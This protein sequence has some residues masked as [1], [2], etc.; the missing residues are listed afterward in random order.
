M[1]NRSSV[2]V[3]VIGTGLAGM[4]AALES[5][6]Q[7]SSVLALS[8][9]SDLHETNTNYAQGGIVTQG[10]KDTPELIAE[11][12][13]R[14][15]GGIN[16]RR[17]VDILARE[18]QGEVSRWLIERGGVPFDRRD[19]GAGYDYTREGAHSVRRIL[20][21]AD[22][23]GAAIQKKLMEQMD[24]HPRIT[25]RKGVTAVDLITNSHHSQDPQEKYNPTRVIG[26][27][28]L[29]CATGKVETVF[30]RSVILAAG[31]VGSLFRHSSNPA[32]ATGDGISMAYRAGAEIINSEYIQFHPTT[33]YHRDVKHFLITEA[34]RGE[35][36]RLMNSRGEYFMKEYEPVDKDLAPRDLVARAIYREMEKEGRGYVFLDARGITKVNVKTRF[37]GIYQ[38][39]L[40]LGIDITAEPIPVVPA[41]HYFC[42]GIK[43]DLE[44]AATVKGLYAAGENSCTGVHGANRLASVSL[45]EALVFGARTGRAAAQGSVVE[46]SLQESIPDWIYPTNET[47]FDS[48]LIRND[49][50]NIQITLW[51]YVGIIRT[52]KR[53]SRAL[54]DLNYMHHRIERFYKEAVIT[55]ELLE[56]RNSVVTATLITR[57]ASLNNQS[58]GCHY[59]QE[60]S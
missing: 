13:I 38:K 36:A 59:I 27:Y 30:A 45:L 51:N 49:L 2:D 11:D 15:G 25:L 41:A 53:L 57:S 31:G 48:V 12:I 26:A 50:K 18:A 29:D 14:A 46:E 34:L 56:L 58:L 19:D 5:A 8:K 37:P 44:G 4:T 16:N 42:G 20:H 21:V 9:Q 40:S 35:G 39:C 32:G 22:Q 1:E 3:L 33:L 28:L 10:L 23:T 43:V 60:H 17:A 47:D 52:G 7:G 24:H 54:S 55:R 6:D